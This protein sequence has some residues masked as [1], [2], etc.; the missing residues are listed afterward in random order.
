[1]AE[2]REVRTE[3]QHGKKQ[4]ADRQPQPFQGT[5]LEDDE[6]QVCDRKV[7][8]KK[9]EKVPASLMKQWRQLRNA[10]G[11][12]FSEIRVWSQPSAF[13]DNIVQKWLIQLEAAE[14]V[15]SIRLIDAFQAGWSQSSQECNFLMQT[16]QAAVAPGM[17]AVSQ[18]TDTGMAQPAKAAARK[19]K[20]QLRD[21]L[22]AKARRE[23]VAPSYKVGPRQLLQV[24][25]AAHRQMHHINITQQAVLREAR[26]GGWL[27]YR[28]AAGGRMERADRQKW[29]QLRHREISAQLSH[30]YRVNRYTWLD[31]RGRPS[32]PTESVNP[33]KPILLEEADLEATYEKEDAAIQIEGD[34]A[35]MDDEEAKDHWQLM[36]APSQRAEH[37]SFL[38]MIDSLPTQRKI[39]GQRRTQKLKN[40]KLRREKA[41]EWRTAMGKKTAQQR[42]AKL[43]PQVGPVAGK[44]ATRTKKARKNLKKGRV[45]KVQN[46]RRN[47]NKFRKRMA[48]SEKQIQ[49]EKEKQGPLLGKFVRY[50]AETAGSLLI[51]SRAEVVAHTAKEIKI[52]SLA[53]RIM[54]V[55]EKDIYLLTGQEKLPVPEQLPDL[56]KLTKEMKEAVREALGR[57]WTH[58]E[59]MQHMEADGL[60]V[61]WHLVLS[62]HLL[63][64]PQEAW[65]GLEPVL[66]SPVPAEAASQAFKR[67]P[68]S[69]EAELAL[70]G[71]KEQL[72]KVREQQTE[73]ALIVA[74]VHSEA[75]SHWSLISMTRAKGQIAWA[76]EYFDS[77]ANTSIHSQYKAEL[78][79]IMIGSCIGQGSMPTELP[80]KVNERTQSDAWSCG[81]WVALRMEELLRE[82]RGEGPK[83]VMPDHFKLIRELNKFAAACQAPKTRQMQASQP[84]L[85]VPRK[86]APE[87]LPGPGP[88]LAQM[89]KLSWGCA[90][91]RFSKRGCRKCNPEKGL[92]TDIASSQ[93]GVAAG[94][95]CQAAGELPDILEAASQ[96]D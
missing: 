6:Y 91:C 40:R 14:Y 38:E 60:A 16:M 75:P 3:R 22:N 47:K 10:G 65:Q 29:A 19:M 79:L 81:Y 94:S 67:D 92:E 55:R 30:Q 83:R 12:G 49:Q 7:I 33:A 50:I 11:E 74:P 31:E 32:L 61:A 48:D 45:S 87:P 66:V 43:V 8:R 27:A 54:P 71:I 37:K 62:K 44:G 53:G 93:L 17:T 20:D 76:V 82:Y 96:S 72:A 88:S 86:P 52:S 63:Q 15:Q 70:R 68:S 90:K 4:R 36:L 89:S 9:G 5:W 28:P 84:S 23:K 18:I 51:N 35:L 58:L 85:P 64:K 25:L 73:A 77:M 41:Q 34:Q 56:R 46:T 26:A 42:F 21:A 57:E 95:E 39:E 59:G 13:V 2:S 78:L 24:A 80:S 69:E 1:M